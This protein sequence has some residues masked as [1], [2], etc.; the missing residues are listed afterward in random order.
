MARL[1]PSPELGDALRT[2]GGKIL[3]AA[4][5]ERDAENLLKSTNRRALRRRL[6]KLR[7]APFLRQGDAQ[8]ADRLAGHVA[9][10][11][12]LASLR[13]AL[14]A[15]MA[16]VEVRTDDI[17]QQVFAA[18]LGDPP[19]ENLVD[20]ISGFTDTIQSLRTRLQ[21]AKHQAEHPISYGGSA[22]G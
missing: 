19:T 22:S 10:I 6:N 1:S 21:E 13:S 8:L 2:L 4:R 5:D 15:E 18:R 11:E 16:R 12:R 14:R 3:Q 7:S 17:Q 20:E 9:A